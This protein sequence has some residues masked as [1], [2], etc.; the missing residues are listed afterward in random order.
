MRPFELRAVWQALQEARW[1]YLFP[2][3]GLFGTGYVWRTL[4]WRTLFAHQRK[5]ALRHLF[6]ALMVGYLGNNLLPARAGEVAR[7]FVLDR[8]AGV[9]KSMT[10][11][12]IV[13]ERVG[14]LLI[15]VSLLA[16]SLRTFPVPL[17][18]KQA[19]TGAAALALAAL[20]F[21][22][23]AGWRGPARV[24]RC[25]PRLP[26]VPLR[27][28]ERL[29]GF[30]QAFAAGVGSLRSLPHLL[31]FAGL[32]LVVWATEI[33]V[34]WVSAAAFHIPLTPWEAAFV[35]LA[36]ALGAMVPAS[37]GYVGT[38][39]FF[40]VKALSLLGIQDAKALGC[41][42]VVHAAAILSSSTVGCIC[43]WRVRHGAGRQLG[44]I[45][46]PFKAESRK[47]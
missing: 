23:L 5:V 14:D 16:A 10:L 39:E 19:G 28:R 38:Y 1:G 40:A 22:I 30:A 42:L 4:R 31:R 26:L 45:W 43:L 47:V 3:L 7:L 8:Q 13:V 37:P 12:T 34:I 25:L 32:T 33:T 18:L 27:L 36:V 44:N 21:L 46:Q 11:A 29:G 35:L 17:A 20:G 6:P 41:V 9:P 15:I 2:I 24:Q